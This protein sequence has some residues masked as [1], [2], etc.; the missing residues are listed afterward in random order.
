MRK[1]FK[2]AGL[3]IVVAKREEAPI[4]LRHLRQAPEDASCAA[5]IRSNSA[6]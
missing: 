4:F 2:F 3:L 5:I 1:A 6:C